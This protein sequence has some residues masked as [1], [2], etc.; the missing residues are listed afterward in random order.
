M[1]ELDGPDVG[2]TDDDGMTEGKQVR[3]GLEDD[4]GIAE[5]VGNAVGLTCHKWVQCNNSIGIKE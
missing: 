3:V 2:L 1:D 4:V 5:L